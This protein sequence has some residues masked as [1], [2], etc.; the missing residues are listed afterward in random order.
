MISAS[1]FLSFS[2]IRLT[3]VVW[4]YLETCT[5]NNLETVPPPLLDRVEVLGGSGYVT[6]ESATMSERGRRNRGH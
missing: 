2:S 6:E 3:R 1:L 5:G 4:T